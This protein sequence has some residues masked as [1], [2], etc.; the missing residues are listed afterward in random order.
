MSYRFVCSTQL[1][2]KGWLAN[3]RTEVNSTFNNLRKMKSLYTYQGHL[4]NPVPFPVASTN[5]FFSNFGLAKNALGLCKSPSYSHFV[6]RSDTFD[7]S[8]NVGS[9]VKTQINSVPDAL[10]L[11]Q[12]QDETAAESSVESV[13][14]I[15][16]SP[17]VRSG[18]ILH[19]AE[20]ERLCRLSIMLSSKKSFIAIRLAIEASF[21]HGAEWFPGLSVLR[22]IDHRSESFV[23]EKLRDYLIE[24][25]IAENKFMDGQFYF[26][27]S[28][29]LV[30]VEHHHGKRALIIRH[31]INNYYEGR[32]RETP[33][34]ALLLVAIHAHRVLSAKDLHDF[35]GPVAWVSNTTRGCSATMRVLKRLCDTGILHAIR[36]HLPGRAITVVPFTSSY[37]D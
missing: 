5:Q 1:N 13:V 34:A 30:D 20:I 7:D 4:A 18:K 8:K 11:T 3:R 15:T 12:D 22:T 6:E 24:L 2:V 31:D 25:G 33:I 21:L 23:G 37:H 26:R 29:E 27:L 32:S 19:P 9:P 36:S 28:G 16:C 17:Q 10:M 14:E 35:M